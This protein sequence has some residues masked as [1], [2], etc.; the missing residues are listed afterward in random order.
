L[1]KRLDFPTGIKLK[2]PLRIPKWIFSSRR[3]LTSCLKGLF[4]TDGD[5]VIDSK[6]L[7]YVIKF[8]N[9]SQS[10]LDDVCQALVGL[11]YHPQRR[12]IDIRLAKKK[13]AFAFAELIA[14]R[15]W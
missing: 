5:F 11:G 10:L 6:H 2:K 15:K 13:E 14:F 9:R 4:E 8:N 7:T 12:K 1:S 3:F